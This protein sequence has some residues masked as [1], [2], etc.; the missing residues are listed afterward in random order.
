LLEEFKHFLPD[1]STVPQ[2]LAV[3][4]GVSV[5]Q[6][7][8]KAKRSVPSIKVNMDHSYGLLPVFISECSGNSEIVGPFLRDHF[9]GAV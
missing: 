9:L 6:D 4:K 5:K 1:T 3:P 7:G 8:D 2:V